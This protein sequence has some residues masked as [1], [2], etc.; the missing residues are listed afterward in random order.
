VGFVAQGA[1]LRRKL[2]TSFAL[3]AA[4][5]FFFA[6]RP[7]RETSIIFCPLARRRFVI[8]SNPS[9]KTMNQPTS[10]H[11]LFLFRNP[12]DDPDPT[13]A[14][15]EKIFGQWMAWMKSLKESGHLAGVNR[16]QDTGKVI[17]SPLGASVTDGPYVEAKEIIG[18]Y[19]LV[20]ARDLAHA[21]TL[22]QGCPGLA[23]GTTVEVRPVEPL[24]AS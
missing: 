17:R 24:P 6:L 21:A 23:Y 10:P 12:Q 1:A 20:T 14:E 19:L 9:N 22:A 8:F 11:Y 16:L 13:P 15:M 4:S 2:K 7:A 18:G 3:R 5:S